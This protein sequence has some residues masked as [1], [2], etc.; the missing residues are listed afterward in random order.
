[1]YLHNNSLIQWHLLYTW[2]LWHLC[3]KSTQMDREDRIR[4][5]HTVTGDPSRDKYTWIHSP[6][7]I[8]FPHQT[9]ILWDKDRKVR[10]SLFFFFLSDKIIHW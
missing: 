6:T 4:G 9:D 7:Q 5:C 2:D 3:H 1:M 8:D 10:E